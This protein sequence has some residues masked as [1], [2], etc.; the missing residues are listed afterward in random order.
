VSNRTRHRTHIGPA[1][2]IGAVLLIVALTGPLKGG[3]QLL[4][5]PTPS[6]SSEQTVEFEGTWDPAGKFADVQFGSASAC[7]LTVA[8]WSVS[9]RQQIHGVRVRLTTRSN[10]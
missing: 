9:V 1:V 2:I 4:K 7:H 8:C 10:Q 6:P 5:P 3:T